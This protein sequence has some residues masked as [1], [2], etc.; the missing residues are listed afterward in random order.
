M[1]GSAA[2]AAIMFADSVL[3]D[4]VKLAA[5]PTNLE[6]R[7][8]LLTGATGF[9]GAHL[10]AVLMSGDGVR[11]NCLVRNA[12]KRE[13]RVR[14]QQMLADFGLTGDLPSERVRFFAGD[15]S[16]PRLGLSEAAH[17]ELCSSTDAI[18]HCA[19]SVN[20]T[21]SYEALRKVN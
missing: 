19:A 5:A 11:V 9:L 17:D 2:H 12:E 13:P 1:G 21:S 18:Y 7:S 8:V 20:W 15:I 3:P 10:L 6:N 16:Q 4:E 14:L